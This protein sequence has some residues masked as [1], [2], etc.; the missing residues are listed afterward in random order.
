MAQRKCVRRLAM[1]YSQRGEK[2]T[3]TQKKTRSEEIREA[4]RLV[5]QAYRRDLEKL[6]DY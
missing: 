5:V 6:K 4:T 2:K 1:K 3:Q